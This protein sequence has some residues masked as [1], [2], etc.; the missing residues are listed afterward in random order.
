[1]KKEELDE[2]T[3]RLGEGFIVVKDNGEDGI[4]CNMQCHS[5]QVFLTLL[6]AIVVANP[7]TKECFK[8]FVKHIDDVIKEV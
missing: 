2:I 4:L 5:P 6:T 3:E 7:E 1:M 8:H